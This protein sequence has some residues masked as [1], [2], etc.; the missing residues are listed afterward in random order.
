MIFTFF[1]TDETISEIESKDAEEALQKLCAQRGKSRYWMLEEI[2][3]CLA[4][5]GNEIAPA[6]NPQD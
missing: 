6:G 1:L 3:V 4:P 2:E 5:T